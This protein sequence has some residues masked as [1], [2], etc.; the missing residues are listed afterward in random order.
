MDRFSPYHDNPGA[1]G[2]INVRPMPPFRY[3]YDVEPAALVR[4]AYYFD[5]DHTDLESEDVYGRNAVDLDHGSAPPGRDRPFV[6]QPDRPWQCD[7]SVR[8]VRPPAW[9]RVPAR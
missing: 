5:Y 4:I 9:S 8:G 7:A 6:M 2:M 3:L 1:F